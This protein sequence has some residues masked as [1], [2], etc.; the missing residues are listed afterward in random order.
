MT[1]PSA[2]GVKKTKNLNLTYS[3]K[4]CCGTSR[5]ARDQP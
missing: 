4:T 5:A 1:F 2:E 3:M